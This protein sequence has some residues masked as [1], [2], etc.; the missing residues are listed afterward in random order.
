MTWCTATIV[1]LLFVICP[2]NPPDDKPEPVLFDCDELPRGRQ[3]DCFALLVRQFGEHVQK[4]GQVAQFDEGAI[5]YEWREYRVKKR[6]ETGYVNSIRVQAMGRGAGGAVKDEQLKE[7]EDTADQLQTV[8]FIVYLPGEKRVKEV[9]EFLVQC[10][11]IDKYTSSDAERSGEQLVSEFLQK[12]NFGLLQVPKGA[13]VNFS[14]P[15]R[16]QPDKTQS[17]I[18]LEV[19]VIVPTK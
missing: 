11:G 17:G 8:E 15:H 18:P 10:L 12:Q 4:N 19:Q 2:S 5:Y 9:V 13:N 16:L 3:K 7:L 6:P 1:G 14:K